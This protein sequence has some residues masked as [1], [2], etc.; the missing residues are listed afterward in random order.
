MMRD[1]TE[2]LYRYF[3]SFGWDVYPENGVPN[4]ARLPYIT[5][6]HVS[7][8][9]TGSTLFYARVWD[10]AATPDACYD[11]A[12]AIARDIGAGA[13]LPLEAGVMWIYLEPDGMKRQSMEGDPSLH[14]VYLSL[15][16]QA[17]A[18]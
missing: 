11:M 7:P 16:M 10:R 6:Q 3:R 14:C 4:A 1:V 12:D 5:V 17:I 13:C 9:W 18:E 15:S 2:A 8:N